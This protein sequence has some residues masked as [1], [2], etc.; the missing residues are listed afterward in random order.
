MTNT[1]KFPENF[2][3]KNNTHEINNTTGFYNNDINF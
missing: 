3:L 2:N 1:K